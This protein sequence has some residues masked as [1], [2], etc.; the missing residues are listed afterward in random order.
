MRKTI[1]AG[2]W[3]MNLDFDEG[4]QLFHAL[5]KLGH[6][7]KA[8]EVILAPP[9][10]YLS[11]LGYTN[12]SSVHF[13]AQNCHH[14]DAGAYTG[15]WSARMLASLNIKH[16]IVGHSERRA[17]YGETNKQIAQKTQQ[18]YA[19]GIRPILCCGETLAE[20]EAGDHFNIVTEQINAV[21]KTIEA[22]QIRTLIIAYEPVWAIGTGVTASA[23]QAQ[24]MH[25]FIRKSIASSYDRELAEQVHILYGGSVKPDNAKE[26]FSLPDVDGGLVGGASLDYESFKGI[27]EAAI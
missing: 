3:K 22:K 13:A 15:E 6:D 1:A 14:E 18:C 21:L 25:S 12:T 27:I 8:T 23:A 9:A 26:L 19:H 17:Q 2:N 16:C 5:T 7:D 11:L 20:R 24:E 4:R 10:P